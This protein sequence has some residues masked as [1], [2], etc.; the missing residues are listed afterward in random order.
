MSTMLSKL[1]LLIL[2]KTTATQHADFIF[3]G[4]NWMICTR[5]KAFNRNV[6]FH[7]FQISN[8]IGDTLIVF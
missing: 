7:Y 3:G 1:V 4:G 5:A 2:F 6:S 8:L